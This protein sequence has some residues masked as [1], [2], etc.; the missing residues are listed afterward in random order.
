M[1]LLVAGMVSA[2]Y[3]YGAPG[4]AQSVLNEVANL[5][6]KYEECRQNGGDAEGKSAGYRKRIALLEAQIKEDRAEL[7]R[8]RTRNEAIEQEIT[9]KQG[10]IRSLEKTLNS[11]D[12]QYRETAAQNE[13]LA[14][15]ANSVKV[16]KIEREKLTR[17]LAEAKEEIARLKKALDKSSPAQMRTEL[18]ASRAQIA[19]LKAQLSAAETAGKPAADKAKLTALQEELRSARAEIAALKNTPPREVVREKAVEKVVYRD[20]IVEKPVEK[21]VEKVVYRDRPVEKIVTRTVEPTEKLKALEKEL[22]TARQTIGQLKN[23]QRPQEKIVEKVVYKDRIVTR[24]K[25]VEKPVEK[26]VY[27]DRP[28]E[29]VVEKVVYRDRPVEKIVTKTAEPTEKLQALQHKLARAEAQI[30][31]LK[32]QVS[33]AQPK[34]SIVTERKETRTAARAML[35]EPAAKRSDTPSGRSAASAYRMAVDAPIFNAPG[36]S[37]VDRWEARRSFTAGPPSAGWVRITGY[38]VNRVWQPAAENESLWVRES[39]VI[40]R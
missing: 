5:R 12:A 22:T 33:P 9:R 6:A 37:I 16:G 36:G 31:Q 38:F 24:E 34:K 1:R 3:L 20:R 40:R 28:V 11:R 17:S 32:A 4:E 27:R 30:A 39:D 8:L 26:V 13:R 19:K 25:V 7:K 35:P 23:A 29:K 21:V 18:E 2:V 15:E 14:R 10:V